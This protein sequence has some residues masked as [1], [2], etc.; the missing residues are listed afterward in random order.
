MTQIIW[1][2]AALP[3]PAAGVQTDFAVAVQGNQ[4]AAV[5][6]LSDLRE[7]YPDA[8]WIGGNDL[9]LMPTFVNSHDHGRAVQPSSLGIPDD[10]L[11]VWLHMLGTQPHISADV[12][13]QYT[14]VQLLKSGVS[15]VAH[16]HSPGTWQG[17]KVEVPFAIEGYQAA[18]IRVVMQPPLLDQHRLVYGDAASFVAG[19]PAT[20]QAVVKPLLDP[21]PIT[22]EAYFDMLDLFYGKFHDRDDHMLHLNVSPVGGQWCSDTLIMQSVEWAK[23]HNSRMHMHLLETQYQQR[24]AQKT[25][26]KSFVQHLDEIG[27][28]GTW[29]TLAHMV[30]V[31]DDDLALLAERG[32]AV[33]H[34]PSSNL[35][36]RSGIA[37]VA[38]MLDAGITVAVGLDSHSLDDDLDYFREL[39]LAWTLANQPGA[40]APMIEAGTVLNMGT[41]NGASATFGDGV[42]LGKLEPGYLADLMLVDWDKLRGK[43]APPSYPERDSVPA[44]LMQRAVAGTVRHVMVNG[45]WQILDGEHATLNEAHIEEDIRGMLARQPIPSQHP[46]AQAMRELAPYLRRYYAAWAAES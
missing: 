34:N 36:L 3:D 5:G 17:L 24:Y 30:W 32:V 44:F 2:I 1:G 28:L 12:A 25:W 11:E 6:S 42:Q 26:G 40:D 13:A 4:I 20:L 7:Q 33:V 22:H 9:L 39:R 37:P 41:V 35:R 45:D 18:G 23:V 8:E 31:D 15:A 10:M 43:W 16:N 38:K 29:L 27:A 46:K 21:I 14:A 19:L